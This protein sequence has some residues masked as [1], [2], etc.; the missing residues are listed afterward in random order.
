MLEQDDS[1]EILNF[2]ILTDLVGDV[3][4]VDNSKLVAV[5]LDTESTYDVWKTIY[6]RL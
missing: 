3:K 4:I 6:D 5:A 2:P 1:V